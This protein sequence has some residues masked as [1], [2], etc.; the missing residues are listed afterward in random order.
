MNYGAVAA[1]HKALWLRAYLRGMKIFCVC[2]AAV[3]LL[4]NNTFAQQAVPVR[5]TRPAM[6]DSL[7]RIYT[8]VEQMPAL[9]T[10]K[11]PLSLQAAVQQQVAD[12]GQAGL[13][14]GKVYV[15]FMVGPS[16]TVFDIKLVKGLSPACDA[17]ALA[18][19]QR[20]PRLRPGRQD[21]QRVTVVAT[22]TVAFGEAAK[23]GKP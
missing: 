19:V 8:Y 13:G 9:L 6:P 22:L 15:R 5:P 3:L 17:A 23:T 14:A 2:L 1:G 21:N 16:G 20:L 4:T 12:A 18:A 11:G 7:K 10:D